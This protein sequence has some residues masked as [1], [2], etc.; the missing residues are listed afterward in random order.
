MYE[1]QGYE[2]QSGGVHVCGRCGWPYP[3]PH[4]SSK[5]R[6]AHKKVCGTVEGYKLDIDAQNK[7]QLM[8]GSDGENASDDE[9]KTP[10]NNHFY[11]SYLC[12]NCL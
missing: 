10:S 7:N 6:R 11:S 8:D 4:P 5:H 3:K 2:G 1:K 9:H 12:V